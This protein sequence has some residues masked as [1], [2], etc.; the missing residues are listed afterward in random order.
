MR[1][2]PVTI[3]EIDSLRVKSTRLS[4][5]RTCWSVLA[6]TLIALSGTGHAGEDDHGLSDQLAAEAQAL[7]PA[8]KILA[9]SATT[10]T[11]RISLG[12]W[13]NIISWTPHLPVT[14]ATLPDGR[15]L[16]FASNQRTTFPVGAEFTYAAV[17]NP[18]T[19][20]FTEINNT[21]HDMFC[22]GTAMLPDGRVM[23]NGGRNT[24]RPITTHWPPK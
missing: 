5:L 19:G 18:A 24:T 15:L 13:G 20:V 8:F 17:W 11:A 9:P 22:G 16:T 12:E 21:R 6:V 2:N 14:A 3:P 1:V 10:A 23:I 7:A 4:A